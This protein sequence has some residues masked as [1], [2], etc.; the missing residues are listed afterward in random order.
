MERK[1]IRRLPDSELEVMQALWECEIPA[2][3]NEIA[4]KM[5]RT[6]KRKDPPAQTT[7]L[8]L[9]TRLEQKGFV[10]IEKQ[11]RGSVYTPLVSQEEYRTVRSRSFV[12]QLFGGSMKA[13]ANALAYGALTEEE[14]SELRALLE[15]HK[16]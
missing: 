10:A 14:L 13:F 5:M 4:E 8:T 15:E 16:E 12:D 11:G 9:L 2:G 6:S 3:R 7:L 1:A